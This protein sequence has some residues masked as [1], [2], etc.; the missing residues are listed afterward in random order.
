MISFYEDYAYMEK[1]SSTDSQY[2]LQAMLAQE[3]HILSAAS[4]PLSTWLARDAIQECREACGGHGFHAGN[5]LFW[6][7]Q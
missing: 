1:I 6:L 4:K 2:D 3:M 5:V 7:L